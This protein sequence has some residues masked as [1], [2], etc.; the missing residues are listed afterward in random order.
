M[1][2]SISNT[3]TPEQKLSGGY[4]ASTRGGSLL[5]AMARTTYTLA[6]AAALLATAALVM[7]RKNHKQTKKS[8]PS[9]LRRKM[10]RRRR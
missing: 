3:L 6:P 9:H 2:E 4:S 7:K 1:E 10:S 5:S 8:R